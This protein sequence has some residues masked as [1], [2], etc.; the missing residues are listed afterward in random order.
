MKKHQK[1]QIRNPKKWPSIS[2]NIK[3]TIHQIKV[4]IQHFLTNRTSLN[5]VSG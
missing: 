1:K 5:F 3:V 2:Q 4:Q